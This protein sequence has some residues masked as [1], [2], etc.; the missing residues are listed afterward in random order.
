MKERPEKVHI[1]T[2]MMN[3]KR[4]V[5]EVFQ[6]IEPSWSK[7]DLSVK[8]TT[9]N[10]IVGYEARTMVT[11]VKVHVQERLVQ[12]LQC[13]RNNQI[14]ALLTEEEYKDQRKHMKKYRDELDQQ[15]FYEQS[16]LRY[17]DAVDEELAKDENRMDDDDTH[18]GVAK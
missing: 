8:D 18:V 15:P 11:N 17:K 14:G 9:R 7:Q 10:Q 4:A 16:H 1:V 5:V 12:A 13:W 3:S 2:T 6:R